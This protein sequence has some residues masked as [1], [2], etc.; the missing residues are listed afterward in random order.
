M[1]KE[2]TI[3]RKHPRVNVDILTD[4]GWGSECES[5]DRISSL[6]LGGCF[7][8][9]KHELHAGDRISLEFTDQAIGKVNLRGAIKYQLRLTEGGGPPGAGVE[10]ISITEDS[11][12]KL[13]A[14]LDGYR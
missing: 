4:W 5:S 11:E 10:F 9:T 1:T 3:V 2:F 8:A 14:V 6:S 7:L 12:K 13:Q